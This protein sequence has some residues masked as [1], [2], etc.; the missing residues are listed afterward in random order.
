MPNNLLPGDAAALG[1]ARVER[2]EADAAHT[3]SRRLL[4]GTIMYSAAALGFWLGTDLGHRFPRFSATMTLLHVLAGLLRLFI[5][6][7]RPNAKL[8]KSARLRWDW[9]L[10]ASAV[11]CAGIF[12]LHAGIAI[13]LLGLSSTTMVVKS[14]AS[15]IVLG[16]AYGLAPRQWLMRACVTMVLG[17]LLVATLA[18]NSDPGKYGVAAMTAFFLV[19]VVMLGRRLGLEYWQAAVA[20][21]QLEMQHDQLL[22][23]KRDLRGLIEKSPDAMGVLSLA[24]EILFVNPAWTASLQYEVVDLIGKKLEELVHPDDVE[25]LRKFLTASSLGSVTPEE[26]SFKRRDDTL[27]TW[28]MGPGQTLEYEGRAARSV[29]A[30]DVTERNRMRMQLQLSKRLSSIG[31]L[32]AGVAHEI[33]NPLT[34]VLTNLAHAQNE[35]RRR[36]ALDAEV[37]GE[38]LT[39]VNEAWE[40]AERVRLIVRDLKTFSRAEDAPASATDLDAAI[41]FAIKITGNEVRHRARLVYAPG[42]VPLVMADQAKLGQVF[43]NLLLNAAD[44]IPEGHVEDNTI[45]IRTRTDEAGY[46][47]VEVSDSG[48][49]ITEANLSR[50][51]DPFFTTKPVGVGTGLGLSICH[52]NVRS[53]GGDISATSEVGRGTTFTVRM[54][55]APVV[56]KPSHRAPPAAAP[57]TRG[58][59]LLI[60]DEVGV[61]NAVQRYL[62]KECDVVFEST[63][64]GALAR[65]EAGDAFDVVLCDLM[66][67]NMT[68][69]EL[70]ERVLERAPDHAS[71]FVF[72]TGGAFTPAAKAFLDRVP[73]D[74]LTK[75]FNMKKLKALLAERFAKGESMAGA[76]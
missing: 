31:T 3:M 24:S 55:V 5:I 72:I 18:S 53:V 2:L 76:A 37:G 57:V 29:V 21:A 20:K 32:A 74:R 66:M 40:G 9:M 65:I 60:D 56:A 51:F 6:R 68:G 27:A 70:F 59:V 4:P 69:M 15:A 13:H 36:G 14:V 48:I 61:G 19:Y 23:S 11:L 35:M 42:N 8:S 62:R 17:S 58:R 43:V 10:G 46:V 44:A 67:P 73:N 38:I 22:R 28:E 63:A 75:P 41:G 54:K 33:N 12:S 45:E 30:R 26:F 71:Q 7:I 47:V 16:L 25:R 52:A 64:A 34:Y 50:I 49:G 1:T 39:S